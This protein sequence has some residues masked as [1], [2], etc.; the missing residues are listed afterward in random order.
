MHYN[1][2]VLATVLVTALTGA[3][4]VATAAPASAAPTT[5]TTPAQL[6]SALNNIFT[7]KIV[8]GGNITTNATVNVPRTVTIDLNGHD[9]TAAG[10]TVPTLALLTTLTLDDSVGGGDLISTGTTTAGID[11]GLLT[12]VVINDGTITATGGANHPGIGGV[13]LLGGTIEINGGVVDATGGTGQAGISAGGGVTI[14]AGDVDANGGAGAPAIGGGL[15]DLLGFVTVGTEASLTVD[16]G[17]GAAA[18]GSDVSLLDIGDVRVAGTLEIPTGETVDLAALHSIIVEATGEVTGGGTLQGVGNVVN[19]GVITVENIV[20]S[21]DGLEGLNITGNNHLLTIDPN[22][23]GGVIDTIRVYSPTLADAGIDIPIAVRPGYLFDGWTT[24]PDGSG[25]LLTAVTS[26]LTGTLY[27]QWI[28]PTD[29]EVTPKAPTVAL[30]GSVDFSVEGYGPGGVE[31]GSYDALATV[32]VSPS[33]G[34]TVNGTVVAFSQP[35]TYTVTADFAGTTETA[36]VTV[37]AGVLSAAT[38]TIS[39]TALWGK[40]LTATTSG[41]TSGATVKYQWLRDGS[42]VVGSGKT[43]VV[44]AAD[45]GHKLTVRV[46]GT[47]THYTPLT[48]TSASKAAKDTAKLAVTYPK[49]LKA[50]KSGKVSFSLKAGK[51]GVKPTGTV[52]VFYSGKKYITVKVTSSK[53]SYSVK[54]PKLKRTTYT[55]HVRYYGSTKYV[56]AKAKTVKVRSYK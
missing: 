21:A 42:K 41:W 14:A 20:D 22:F 28:A 8:L 49:K 2:P 29:L 26:L 36:T 19:Q 44:K 16:G 56:A 51:S 50:G 55:M 27:A 37:T 24:N 33:Q 47:K 11:L 18:L 53:S 12:R 15:L 6:T 46:T 23:E 7:E 4:L 32:T 48:K 52:K 35:G 25:T 54:L 40:T 39:G 13:G 5:V 45:V 30:G 43:Y 3:S 1:K 17:T 38:P 31:M 9:L 10:V 34:A